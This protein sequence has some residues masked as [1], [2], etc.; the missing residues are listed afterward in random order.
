MNLTKC[1]LSGMLLSVMMSF[2]EDKKYPELIPLDEKANYKIKHADFISVDTVTILKSDRHVAFPD[3]ARLKNNKLMIAYR[4]GESHIDDSGKL[5]KLFGSADGRSWGKPELLYDE[6]G[7]D[8]R[9]ASIVVMSNGTIAINTFKYREGDCRTTPRAFTNFYSVS[10]DNGATFSPLKRVDQAA[11]FPDQ[12]PSLINGVWHDEKLNPLGHYASSSPVV[13]SKNKYI[14]PAYGGPSLVYRIK[15]GKFISKKWRIVFF[16][17]TDKGLTW[18]KRYINP[19]VDTAYHFSEPALLSLKDGTMVMHFRSSEEGNRHGGLGKMRQSVSRDGGLTWS[20]YT[21][22]DFAGHAPDLTELSNGILVSSFRVK[23][24][25]K[26]K[27]AFMYSLDKGK[28]WS[29]VIDIYESKGENGYPS[30]V[31]L[32]DQKFMIVYY[33]DNARGLEGQIFKVKSFYERV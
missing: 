3:V 4:E 19:S 13:I 24:P 30:I 6:P 1:V 9:E 20:E 11:V 22:F 27:T 18:K 25:S 8:D 15:D 28:S 23:L 7:R 17:S 12:N 5:M 14:L 10:R 16:E 26:E 2:T 33:T 32:D 21:T 31:E 29:N